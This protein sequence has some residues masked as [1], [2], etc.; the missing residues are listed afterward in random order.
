M[1]YQIYKYRFTCRDQSGQLP[2]LEW[3]TVTKTGFATFYTA[4]P[5]LV[6]FIHELFPQELAKRTVRIVQA[7]A[8]GTAASII[9]T[10]SSFVYATLLPFQLFTL[11]CVG[12]IL[13]VLV[14]ALRRQRPGARL[15]LFGVFIL[16][17][18]ALNDIAA[19]YF[20]V[21]IGNLAPFGLLGFIFIQATI[22][23]TR[24][25]RAFKDVEE[26]SQKLIQSNHEREDAF[27][28]LKSYKDSLQ[29]QVETRTAELIKAKEV[30]EQASQAKS[31]FLATMSHE[32]RTPMNGMLLMSE[33]LA[34]AELTPKYRRYAEV[35]MKSGKSLLAIIND[36]LDLSKIQ[37]GKLE[38]ESIRTFRITTTTQLIIITLPTTNLQP[39]MKQTTISTIPTFLRGIIQ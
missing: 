38:L 26:L 15:I 21:P 1:S 28:E 30:A 29:N 12:L 6:M 17:V 16:A 4:V 20:A 22:L 25:S 23:A 18:S 19:V 27:S 36:I 31:E 10:P 5:M 35:I 34:T 32:I 14:K 8:F 13:T 7:V 11:C 33:L 37:S 24:F 2:G 39:N 9:F 3:Q